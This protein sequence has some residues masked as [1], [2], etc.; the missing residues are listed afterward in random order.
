MKRYHITESKHPNYP[1]VIFA[2]SYVS[3][4]ESIPLMEKEPELAGYKGLVLFDLL[5]SN[6]YASNRFITLEV[7][8][9]RFD[10]DSATIVDLKNEE[11]VEYCFAFHHSHPEYVKKSSLLQRDKNDLLNSSNTK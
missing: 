2:T 8:D 7:N 11:I 10:Y 9:G 6:G 1:L 4:V 5:L 3:P